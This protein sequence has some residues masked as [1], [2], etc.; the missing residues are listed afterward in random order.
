MPRT[1]DDL[2]DQRHPFD[3]DSRCIYPAG[4]Q[5]RYAH[6]AMVMLRFGTRVFL[7]W[8]YEDEGRLDAA[9]F[10]ALTNVTCRTSARR[11]SFSGPE[12]TNHPK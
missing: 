1:D 10:V 4:H 9:V 8:T 2:C 6:G 7:T 11:G 5:D 3:I 12:V